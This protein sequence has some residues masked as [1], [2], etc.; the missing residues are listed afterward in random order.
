MIAPARERFFSYVLVRAAD[1]M[2][3]EHL[4]I[5]VLVYDPVSGELF[6]KFDPDLQRVE[7][8]LPGVRLSHLRSLVNSTSASMVRRLDRNGVEMLSEAHERWA[9]VL[10]ASPLRS[11]LGSDL[12]QTAEALFERY[13]L[14]QLKESSDDF[15]VPPPPGSSRFSDGIAV[16]SL[17]VRLERAKLKRG[18]DFFQNARLTGLTK[19]EIA[20]PVWFPLQVR[21]TIFMDGLAIHGDPARDFDL[22]RLAAQKA[23]QTLRAIPSATVTVAVRDLGG[24]SLG[25]DVTAIIEGDGQ[26]GDVG[27]QVI[28]YSDAGDLD[29]WVADL[30]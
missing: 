9:N 10:R 20:V 26:V 3:G 25:E 15:G 29:S 23:E 18:R 13:V 5:G 19:N 24:S 21:H 4:N 7:A 12:Y 8:T 27:P 2:R 17:R 28:R 30:V 1:E 22:A 14:V 11:I 16:R 6:P